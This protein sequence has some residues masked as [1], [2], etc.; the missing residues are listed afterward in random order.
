MDDFR[1]TDGVLSFAAAPDVENPTDHNTDNV[2]YVTIEV[3]D[4]E[5]DD[6]LH[7]TVVVTDANEE[8]AFPGATTS[9]DIYREHFSRSGCRRAC[10]RHRPR[11][12]IELTYSLGGADQASTST[13]P[14]Q[15]DRLLD[16]VRS[17]TTRAV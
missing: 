9:R 16:E 8:P 7:V 4:R 11:E 3:T 10:E 12:E 5:F 14:R 6:Q 15:L 1:I 2:Y 17:W 13:S